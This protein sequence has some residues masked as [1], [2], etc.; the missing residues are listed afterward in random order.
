MRTVYRLNL[1]GFLLLMTSPLSA[2]SLPSNLSSEEVG[3]AI[4]IFGVGSGMRLLRSSEALPDWP[5]F[6]AGVELTLQP[7]KNINSLG[8]ANGT[9]PTLFPMP[10]FYFAKG[11]GHGGELLIGTFPFIMR[12]TVATYGALLKWTVRPEDEYFLAT[13]VFAGYTRMLALNNS[14]R[15]HTLEVGI[16]VSKD[17]VRLRPYG[18]VAFALSVGDVGS[19]SGLTRSGTVNSFKLFAGFELE[20]PMSLS[21]QL[22]FLDLLPS[23]SVLVGFRL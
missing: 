9:L 17:Y 7:M 2:A 15:A 6:K 10:R 18:G 12:N 5:G 22:D 20:L 13:A 16:S 11:L 23:A 1:V 21:V 4:Q 19:G 14:L 3:R 8:N